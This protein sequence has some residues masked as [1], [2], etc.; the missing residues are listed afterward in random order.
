MI[1]IARQASILDQFDIDGQAATD[2][3]HIA[4]H[5][6]FCPQ[7]EKIDLPRSRVSRPQC[8]FLHAVTA[9][10][11]GIV[12]VPAHHVFLSQCLSVPF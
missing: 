3:R 8:Q 5:R 11:V 1:L 2:L 12:L 9:T 7:Q 10:K 6:E 4:V